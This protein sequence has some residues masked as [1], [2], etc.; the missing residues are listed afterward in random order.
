[1]TLPTH[2]GV[3]SYL[4]LWDSADEGVEPHE[5]RYPPGEELTVGPTSML[6]FRAE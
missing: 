2:E 1:M 5:Q 4:L 3:T 6:L